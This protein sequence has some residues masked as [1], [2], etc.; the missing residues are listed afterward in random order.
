M[1]SLKNR[2]LATLY[3]EIAKMWDYSKNT[4]ITPDMVFPSV[5]DKVWWK[6][7]QGHEWQAA[8]YSRLNGNGCPYCSGQKILVGYNDLMTTNPK[9]AEEWHPTKNSPLTPNQVTAGSKKEVWWQCKI[10]HEWKSAVFV[11][12]MPKRRKKI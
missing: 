11:L 1:F 9:L 8:V 5:H 12:D 6:C 10:G 4:P 7:E 3:P 2:S